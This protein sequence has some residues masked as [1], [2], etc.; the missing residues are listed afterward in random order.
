[1]ASFVLA[2]KTSIAGEAICTSYHIRKSFTI[3]DDGSIARRARA[4]SGR[5]HAYE[6]AAEM[7][8][9]CMMGTDTCRIL[10]SWAARNAQRFGSQ[11]DSS[12]GDVTVELLGATSPAIPGS[13]SCHNLPRGFSSDLP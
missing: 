10:V 8:R 1:M 7:I 5:Q 11:C 9:P 13:S 4:C 12:A 6:T 2:F 3:N